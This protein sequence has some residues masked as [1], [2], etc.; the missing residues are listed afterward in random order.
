V[1]EVTAHL[2]LV[3]RVATRAA[4]WRHR[5]LPDHPELEAPHLEL[6]VRT[7]PQYALDHAVHAYLK[8][9]NGFAGQPWITPES[10]RM[11][12]TMF[13]PTD[14][15][16]EFGSGGSTE[17]LSDHVAHVS[18]IEAFDH[19]HAALAERLA[20]RGTTNVDLF[21]ASADELGYETAA[22]RDQYVNAHADVEP[23]SLDFVFV[24]GEYRDDCALRGLKLLRPG[25]LF[26]LDN[27]NAYM[28]SPSRSPW[29]LDRPASDKWAQFLQ[30]VSGWR[31]V[32]TTNGVWDTTV[33]IK[34]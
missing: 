4:L 24:D 6:R 5:A 16:I 27:S 26:V 32:W 21:L 33:W 1:D 18:S 14:V 28:P 12:E 25:G 22:H 29:K 7:V 3:S 2:N 34:P 20:Q 8:R 11:L 31:Y 10:K 23:E 17:W 15:G 13:L 19:W 30:E 9:R